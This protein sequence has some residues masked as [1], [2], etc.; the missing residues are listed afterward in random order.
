MF[1]DV[2]IEQ[3]STGAAHSIILNYVY[4]QAFVFGSNKVNFLNFFNN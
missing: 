2:K 1:D 3:I 4:R